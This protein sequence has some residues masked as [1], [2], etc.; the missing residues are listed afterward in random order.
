[1]ENRDRGGQKP[2]DFTEPPTWEREPDWEKLPF[3]VK[4]RILKK[5]F[6]RNVLPSLKRHSIAKTRGQRRRE[7]RLKS[8][9]RIKKKLAKLR[10]RGR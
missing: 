6:Q 9:A 10:E 8:L 5:D 2:I 1:M 3:P 4:I 7:S